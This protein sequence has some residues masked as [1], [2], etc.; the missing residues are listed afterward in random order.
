[1]QS[2]ELERPAGCNVAV[3]V[4]PRELS[5]SR[6]MGRL[7]AV[8]GLVGA[9]ERDYRAGRVFGLDGR[10]LGGQRMA[11]ARSKGLET[12]LCAGATVVLRP[13]PFINRHIWRR[14]A[15]GPS[16]WG[17]IGVTHTL[18]TIAVAEALG[19]LAWAPVSPADRLVCTSWSAFRAL[20]SALDVAGDAVA[21]ACG[22]ASPQRIG[23]EVI[24]LGIETAD[25]APR[26]G[27]D[28]RAGD[29]RERLGY[30]PDEIVCVSV[31][32]LSAYSK[33]Y[34]F[35]AVVAT[36]RAARET[37]LPFRMVFVGESEKERDRAAFL[38]MVSCADVGV[39]VDVIE[40]ASDA[41]L[42]SLLLAADVYLALSDNVQ[43]TFGLSVVEAMAAGLPVVA[44]DWD[45]LRDTVRD[46]TD[47]FLITTRTAAH[48]AHVEAC[49]EYLCGLISYGECVGSAA[50]STAV[51]LD[52]A[53]RALATLGSNRSVRI[54]MGRSAR[55]RAQGEF[56]WSVVV[57]KYEDLFVR[58][59]RL[60]ESSRSPGRPDAGRVVGMPYWTDMLENFHGHATGRIRTETSVAIADPQA[61]VDASSVWGLPQMQ[62]RAHRRFDEA[63]LR[64]ILR[65][66]AE[67]GR[68]SVRQ[69][70]VFLKAERRIDWVSNSVTFLAKI[71]ALRVVGP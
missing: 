16:A 17:V 68:C 36:G 38:E 4:S 14:S 46:G 25:F 5:D 22:G 64:E 49:L 37:G 43:E 41:E 23:L 21:R 9:L 27:D 8:R 20:S 56:D 3:D 50:L 2:S 6:R 30:G 40:D 29:V 1:M 54:E 62:L 61:L 26:D 12:S 71:G 34:P 35:P 66:V 52:E 53:V 31:G 19:M 69:L 65:V 42:R 70:A 59:A 48:G 13:D 15:V 45:G 51:D 7:R 63:T 33:A 18:S 10:E 32:R 67:S 24:P 11:G 58:Q 55:R 39:A 44:A 28:A 57:G 47:G 60:L